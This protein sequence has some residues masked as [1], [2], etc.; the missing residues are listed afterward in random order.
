MNRCYENAE[1]RMARQSIKTLTILKSD[2]L[3]DIQREFDFICNQLEYRIPKSL[4]KVGAGLRCPECGEEIAGVFPN[5]HYC[6]YCT[7]CGQLVYN[8][9]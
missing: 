8:V 9:V 5:D 4:R 2:Q 7:S 6:G 3:A 1:T